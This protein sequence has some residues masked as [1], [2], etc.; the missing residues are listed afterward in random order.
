MKLRAER[1]P[2][3]EVG[4]TTIMNSA[5]A[6]KDAN[7]HQHLLCEQARPVAAWPTTEETLKTT[8]QNDFGAWIGLGLPCANCRAYYRADLAFCPICHCVDRL[9]A[10]KP[11]TKGPLPDTECNSN[12]SCEAL[13]SLG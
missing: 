10:S 3:A 6:A 13:K 12:S 1:A 11:S 5:D 9:P 2:E 8:G 4:A 7:S